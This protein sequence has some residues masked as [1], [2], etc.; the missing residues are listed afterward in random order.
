MSKRVILSLTPEAFALLRRV[1]KR[2]LA[3]TRAEVLR[4]ALIIG[5][6][7]MAEAS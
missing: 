2:E 6:R 4:R 3:V 7:Q 1:K 5:L